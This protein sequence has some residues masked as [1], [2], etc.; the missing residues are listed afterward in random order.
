VYNKTQVI[1]ESI[2]KIYDK[3]NKENYF[4]LRDLVLKSDSMNKDKGKHGKFD[5]LWKGPFIIQA[6]KGNNTFLLKDINGADLPGGLVND[7]ILKHYVPPP[8]RFLV[9][10]FHCTNRSFYFYFMCGC[11]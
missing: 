3:R 1:Q 6:F 4:K 2:K 9:I 8:M 11:C 7:R 5:S 10:Q